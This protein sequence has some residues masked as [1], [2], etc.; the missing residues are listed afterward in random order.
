MRLEDRLQMLRKE[1]GY[2]QE[3][4]ADR[5]G[6]ARQ[7]VGKWESGKAVPELDSLI[8][9]SKLYGLTIDRLV[10]DDGACNVS[11]IRR[12]ETDRD[13]LVE[14]LIRAKRGT[15]AGKGKETEPSRRA[16]HD[17][18]WKEG[19]LYYYDTYLGGE[20][21]SGEEAV[22]KGDVPI[23]SMNYTGRVT[24]ENFS[25]DFLKEALSQVTAKLPYRGPA[26]FRCGDYCYHCVVKGEFDWFQGYEEI[27]CRDEKIYECC[28]HGGE[29]K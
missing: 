15:Y 19:E 11:R 17:L 6:I 26:V 24:G 22:W 4:L 29:V 21:F 13:L 20:K 12:A 23:W 25:G 18:C 8:A 27:F 28:F 9:L 14:F 5:L 3:Q 10:K 16:S 1:K 2:S 7:T